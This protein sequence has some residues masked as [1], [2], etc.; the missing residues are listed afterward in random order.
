MMGLI[1]KEKGSFA[2]P[3]RSPWSVSCMYIRDVLG[4]RMYDDTIAHRHPKPS[5]PPDQLARM[6]SYGVE[7]KEAGER[8][9]R[10]ASSGSEGRAISRDGRR[11]LFAGSSTPSGPEGRLPMH[12]HRAAETPVV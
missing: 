7:E 2:M 8:G 9:G 11:M 10:N 3:S 12:M 1:S 5:H 4:I 6:Y